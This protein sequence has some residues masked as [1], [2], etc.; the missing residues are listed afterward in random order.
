MSAEEGGRAGDSR[1]CCM[2]KFFRGSIKGE[3]VTAKDRLSGRITNFKNRPQSSQ[4]KATLSNSTFVVGRPSEQ[5]SDIPG[6][7]YLYPTTARGTPHGSSHTSVADTLPVPP[8]ISR[9]SSACVC[10]TSSA[11]IPLAARTPSVDTIW[12]IR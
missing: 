12:A 2:I 3:R 5:R 9:T 7:R 8:S 1:C 6:P 11:T 10:P 4:Q